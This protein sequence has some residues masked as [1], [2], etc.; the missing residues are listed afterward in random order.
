MA[1]YSEKQKAALDNLM[2]DDV[3]NHAMEIIRTDG[4]DGMTM[5]RLANDIGVSR[6]TLYNYFDDKDAVIDYVE[7]RSFGGLIEAIE[8]IAARDLPPSEK[9]AEVARWLFTAVFE[10]S[11]LFIALKPIKHMRATRDCH[12]ARR[13]RAMRSIGGI[14]HEG[15]SDGS[16][17]KLSPVIVSEIFLGALTGM[18]EGMMATGEFYRAD[19][20]VPTLMDL[21]LDGLRT[22]A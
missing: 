7:D 4:I 22:T 2:R 15:M 20:V 1:R 6:G 9:L 12:L 8:A 5:E 19:A 11:A 18:L 14:I 13:D 3:H 17:R 21:F 10:D 16:F